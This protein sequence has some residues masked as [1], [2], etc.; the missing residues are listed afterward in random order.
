MAI[1]PIQYKNAVVSIGIK[2]Q[3]KDPTRWIGTGFFVVRK[4]D[5][6]N[7]YSFLITNKHVIKG[8]ESIFMR[9]KE[10][11]KD[12]WIEATAELFDKDKNA[13]FI[14]HPK[15]EI[16][17]AVLPLDGEFITNNNL[18][19][20]AFDIDENAMTSAE[21]RENGVDD[22]STIY[23]LGFPLGMVPKLSTHPICR[24][25]CIAR[26]SE[27]QINEQ[28][29]ILIDIQNFPGNSGSPI[30]NRPE[31]ISIKGTKALDKSV[32]VGIIHS[33]I[34]YKDTLISSQ[35]NKVVEYRMENSGL[36]Y[37]H[38]VEFIR[39]V[40]DIACPRNAEN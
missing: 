33:Y 31:I 29:N 38:P 36:A 10:K 4:I 20:P 5:E 15:D 13:K 21:L 23:M 40:I 2:N 24:L 3:D 37:A 16:D 9:M 22:G 39:E 28:N 12:N 25:G 17:I 1:I 14:A 7:I 19:F 8:S 26:I 11:D 34:P 6:S 27:D 35:T 18:E 32:L 30:I